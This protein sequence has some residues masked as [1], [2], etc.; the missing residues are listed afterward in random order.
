MGSQLGTARGQR[1]AP[2]LGDDRPNLFES[3]G[4]V[5]LGNL[6]NTC[7]MN[8]G[9]QCLCHLEPLVVYFLTGK[10]RGEIRGAGG[11]GGASAN[12]GGS[13]GSRSVAKQ[14]RP[15]GELTEA[16]AG[17]VRNLWQ[18]VQRTH[19]PR[20]LHALFGRK[21]PFL[22]EGYEQQD[23]QEFLA[24]LLDALH[25]DLNLVHTQQSA[26]EAEAR[27]RDDEKL[28]AGRCEEFV[29]ALAW[30]R[31]LQRGKSFLVD[32]LQGQLRDTLTCEVCGFSRRRFEAFLYLSVPV[33]R[34]MSSLGDAIS[35]YLE[36]EVLRGDERW[37]CPQCDCKVDARKNISLWKL[38]PVLV[39]HLKRFEFDMRTFQFRKISTALTSALTLDLSQYVSSPQREAALY[40]VV[41]VANHHGAFGSGHY[42]AY[43]RI[44]SATAK[45]GGEWHHFDD[46]RVKA[47]SERHIISKDAYVIFLMRRAED[48]TQIRRQTESRPDVWPHQVSERNS[49]FKA[50]ISGRAGSSGALGKARRSLSKL[51]RRDP[52]ATANGRPNENAPKKMPPEPPTATTTNGTSPPGSKSSRRAASAAATRGGAADPAATHAAPE[53]SGANS[54]GAARRP[55]STGGLRKQNSSGQLSSASRAPPGDGGEHNP[56]ARA[57]ASSAGAASAAKEKRLRVRKAS[58]TQTGSGSGRR[59]PPSRPAKPSTGSTASPSTG[60]TVSPSAAASSPPETPSTSSQAQAAS[61]Q[62][63][64]P[65]AAAHVVAAAA[66][67]AAPAAAGG[68]RPDGAELLVSAQAS[69]LMVRNVKTESVWD[70]TVA[71]GDLPADASALHLPWNDPPPQ[72]REDGFA[73]A[74]ADAP[75][76]DQGSVAMGSGRAAAAAAGGKNVD[77][78]LVD[79]FVSRTERPRC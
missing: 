1:W 56:A 3:A 75:A 30:L 5:G 10:Y 73:A 51:G 68:G 72:P 48:G 4:K 23:V 64:A 67:A 45:A 60:S 39:L 22:F 55:S 74:A 12:G 49:V 17:L 34:T 6:G 19:K 61:P 59:H 18:K 36:E 41:A 38:P 50:L 2:F 25:E 79:T 62:A 77:E 7:F 43:C 32:L 11:G 33:E 40:D 76:A 35:K 37:L 26:Q 20:D 29:A 65:Q 47:I 27:A 52:A 63:A 13:S 24:F 8:A 14:A 69:A 71:S 70:C 16:F 44:S 31:Y 21:A 54:N 58:L 53:S 66:A 46:D 28:V 9:L 15:P 42:T 78:G 57:G